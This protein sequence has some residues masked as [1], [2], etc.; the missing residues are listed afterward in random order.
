VSLRSSLRAATARPAGD[1]VVAPLALDALSAALARSLGFRAVYLG[2]GAL[3]YARATSEALLTLTEVAEACRAITERVDV[4]VVVDATTGFGDAVHG[5]RTVRVLEQA[6]AAAIELEDQ[7]SPKRAHHHQGIDHMVP[8]E[9]MVGRLEAAVAARTDPDLLVIARCNSLSHDGVQDAE[10]RVAAYAAAG[11]DLVMVLPQAPGELARVAA[12]TDLPL[13]TFTPAPDS[14]A[15]L[16]DAGVT[17]LCDP[18]SAT[19]LGLRALR[20][21]Y[22]RLR[23]GEDAVGGEVREALREAGELMGIE[24]LYA[25]ERRTTERP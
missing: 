21:G 19:V 11:A 12:A 8:L 23:A 16:L 5:A 6:G 9:E 15:A 10:E 3:G 4:A 24:E 14:R 2:G 18:F 22:E 25:I 13:V 20:E 1:L 7:L 17:L